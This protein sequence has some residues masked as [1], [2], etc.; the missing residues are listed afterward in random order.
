MKME[1]K[2]IA[3]KLSEKLISLDEIKNEEE[4]QI[5]LKEKKKRLIVWIA[6]IDGTSL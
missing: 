6:S 2:E 5:I 1:S 4:K 3:K